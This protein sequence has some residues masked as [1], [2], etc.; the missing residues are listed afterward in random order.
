MQPC[1]VTEA[2]CESS[3]LQTK[4]KCTCTFKGPKVLKFFGDAHMDLA[5]GGENRAAQDIILN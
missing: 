1:L 3:P 2:M 5:A 4:E